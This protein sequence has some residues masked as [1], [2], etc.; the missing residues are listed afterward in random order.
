MGCAVALARQGYT[1]IHVW[2]S[3]RQIGEVGAGINITPNLSRILD[4]WGVLDIARNE[5][6]ALKG[7]SVMG[8]SSQVRFFLTRRRTER[9][10]STVDCASDEV[11]TTVD[12][13]YIEKEFGWPFYV[14]PDRLWPTHDLS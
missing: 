1:D 10:Y 13:D 3:A 9:L 11:L 6:V 4:G 14:S 5:A 7:A 2:E 12:F 8:N